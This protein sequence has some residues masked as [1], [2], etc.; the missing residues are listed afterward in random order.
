VIAKLGSIL[1]Q[2][3]K[4]LEREERSTKRRSKRQQ[5]MN[6]K[7]TGVNWSKRRGITEVEK[8]DLI[9][10]SAILAR[11]LRRKIAAPDSP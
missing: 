5:K 4:D 7:N 6:Q 8:S 10:I 3:V 1:D 9:G 2:G 11:L